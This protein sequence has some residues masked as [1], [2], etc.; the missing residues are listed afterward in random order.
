MEDRAT[1]GS[2]DATGSDDGGGDDGSGDGA[3]NDGPMVDGLTYLPDGAPVGQPTCGE[4]DTWSTTAR[5]DSIAATDFVRFGAISALGTT[6]AWTD[7]TGTIY[8]ADRAS[9]ADPFGT[10]AVLDPGTTQLSNGRVALT[11]TG[12]EL[13]A[14]LADGSSFVGFLRPTIGGAWQQGP[15][16]EFKYLAATISESGGA[17][18]EPVVSGNSLSLFYD[19]VIDTGPPI[20]YEAPWD[21]GLK[22]WDP[23]TPL[24][25]PDFTN[26]SAA[27]I[28]RPT[29]AS[30]DQ[31]TLFFFDEVAGHERAAWRDSAGSPFDT[32]V[33]LPALPEAAPTSNC[34]TLYYDGMD[35]MGAGLF[36]ASGM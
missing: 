20:F 10:P 2:N 13:V 3:A 18:S 21:S 8:V 1:G 12:L 32:F 22:A 30:A 31:R 6:A 33:D 15:G 26:A 24:P 29:G 34:R 9:N 5:V 35:T 23:G 19:L 4:A 25:N 27:Q 28:R 36:T 14:T 11:P 16:T 17:F 7:A